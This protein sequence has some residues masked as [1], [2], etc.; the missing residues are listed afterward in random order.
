MQCDLL[1]LTNEA[2][3]IEMDYGIYR[4]LFILSFESKCLGQAAANE[5]YK[6]LL[7]N[8]CIFQL[9]KVYQ[10]CH[11]RIYLGLYLELSNIRN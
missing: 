1:C 9:A 11:G 2:L 10:K 4:V 6:S 3:P 7:L 5:I 8:I